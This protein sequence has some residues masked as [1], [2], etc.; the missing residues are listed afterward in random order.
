[1]TILPQARISPRKKPDTVTISENVASKKTDITT[2]NK[3]ARQKPDLISNY[4][5]FR[6]LITYP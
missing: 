2:A 5:P 3:K 6:D 1:M 4:L